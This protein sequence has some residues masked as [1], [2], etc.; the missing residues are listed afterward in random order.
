[1]VQPTNQVVDTAA[2]PW[3]STSCRQL[4]VDKTALSV[5]MVNDTEQV[6]KEEPQR[7]RYQPLPL[8]LLV[9]S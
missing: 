7:E 5:E 6:E 2:A 8:Q 4:H 1:M 9:R 3:L